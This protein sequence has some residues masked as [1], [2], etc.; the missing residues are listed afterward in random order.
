MKVL[1]RYG[2]IIAPLIIAIFISLRLIFSSIYGININE[3]GIK[4]TGKIL[5]VKYLSGKLYYTYSFDINGETFISED[6]FFED[7]FPNKPR[8][9][10]IGL[11]VQ[12]LYLENNPS[13]SKLLVE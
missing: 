3:Q 1:Y 9:E 12:I 11:D 4:T 7:I 8:K 10:E 5:N 2:W 13:Y 6:F